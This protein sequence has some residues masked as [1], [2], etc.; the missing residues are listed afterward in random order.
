M[1]IKI[2]LF[3]KIYSNS[4]YFSRCLLAIFDIGFLFGSFSIKTTEYNSVANGKMTNQ[5]LFKPWRRNIIKQAAG[6]EFTLKKQDNQLFLC[7]CQK[8]NRQ[9]HFVSSC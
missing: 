3:A 5:T 6:L 2:G 7:D 8:F 1:D 9:M 4:N